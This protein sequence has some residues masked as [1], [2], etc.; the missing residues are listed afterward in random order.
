[1]DRLP[2]NL[3]DLTALGRLRYPD[4]LVDSELDDLG[5]TDDTADAELSSEGRADYL[6]TIA[7]PIIERCD[8]SELLALAQQLDAHMDQWDELAEYR[9][10]RFRALRG[11]EPL[12]V[13]E[14][15]G[16]ILEIEQM[17]T[18]R[19]E[20]HTCFIQAARDGE[21][22]PSDDGTATRRHL[23]ACVAFAAVQRDPATLADILPVAHFCA[24]AYL[25]SK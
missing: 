20:Q 9:R 4:G 13:P 21:P 14:L 19:Y 2:F 5:L 16:I 3:N 12:P 17:R 10:D 25:E 18:A 11:L 1:M 6:R 8:D 15:A 7:I 24:T 22:D 23:L